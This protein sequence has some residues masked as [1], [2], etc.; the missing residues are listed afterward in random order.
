[1]KDMMKMSNVITHNRGSNPVTIILKYVN[2]LI[3]LFEILGLLHFCFQSQFVLWIFLC[4]SSLV[5]C[6]SRDGCDQVDQ[7]GTLV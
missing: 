6:L 5:Q 3:H 4:I 1:M 2:I 7:E